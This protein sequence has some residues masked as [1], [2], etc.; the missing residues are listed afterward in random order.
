[1]QELLAHVPTSCRSSAPLP[2]VAEHVRMQPKS[3]SAHFAMQSCAALHDALAA[4]A[5]SCE[6]HFCFVHVSHAGRLSTVPI[7]EQS[8]GVPELPPSF[9]APLDPPLDAPP[10]LDA[11]LEPPLLDAFLSPGTVDPLDPSPPGGTKSGGG[12]LAHAKKIAARV[13]LPT[14]SSPS[15]AIL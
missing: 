10:E 14:I 13:R 9:P 1:M 6:Q 3:S 12:S 2:P 8:A 5:W 15:F 4:H 11:P 7:F